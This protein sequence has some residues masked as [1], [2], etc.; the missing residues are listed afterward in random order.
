VAGASGVAR[1]ADL[2]LGDPDAVAV[3]VSVELCSLTLQHDD[4]TMA[5]IVASGLF[6]DGAAAVVIV[7]E[8]RA[9]QMGAVG[10]GVVS[11]HAHLFADTERVM[12]WDVGSSGLRVVL[13]Q[14]VPDLVASEMHAV[15][16]EHLAKHDL[17]ISDVP[18]WIAHSGGPK[19]LL[20]LESALDLPRASTLLTWDS[21]H[22]LGN[23]SSASVLDVLGRTMRAT[24]AGS[25]EPAMLVAMGPGF[26]AELVLLRW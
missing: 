17:L 14:S 2:L 15:V 21:L 1:V 25:G 10:P 7:G 16:V 12:G 9:K 26:C 5:N 20:A 18:I 22:E 6:G 8:R 3:L 24:A 23:L 4:A 13:S 11:S 19:V